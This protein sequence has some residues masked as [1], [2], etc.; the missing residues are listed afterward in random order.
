MENLERT[1]H[2]EERSIRRLQMLAP[3]IRDHKDLETKLTSAPPELRS[4]IYNTVKP[5]L[6]FKAKPLDTY[7][8]SAGVMAEQKQLPTLDVHGMLHP[9]KPAADLRSVEKHAEEVIA[10]A[11]AE[12]TLTLTCSKCTRNGLFY[13]VG[14]ET[15]VAVIMKARKDGWVYDP[16]NDV[17]ICPDC[18]TS[19]RQN[20]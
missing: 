15:P 1:A 10:S 7:V 12:R 2:D 3:K 13:A 9:F 17:D 4:V 6:R 14:D 11:L 19:L 16:K 8:A 18:P 5:Y 20:A